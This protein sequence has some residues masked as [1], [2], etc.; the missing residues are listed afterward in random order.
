M[1]QV[2]VTYPRLENMGVG[3]T[4]TVVGYSTGKM[5]KYTHGGI[6]TLPQIEE[7]DMGDGDEL[8]SDGSDGINI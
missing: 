1:Y 4:R 7:V 2:T 6:G 8:N 3:A 5:M